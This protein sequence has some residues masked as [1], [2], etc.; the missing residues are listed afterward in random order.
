[1]DKDL[2]SWLEDLARAVVTSPRRAARIEQELISLYGI[3]PEE[4]AEFRRFLTERVAHASR[5]AP[6]SGMS[7]LAERFFDLGERALKFA[8]GD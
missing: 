2:N 6:G 3:S 1:M 5:G 8:R 4:Q 7:D